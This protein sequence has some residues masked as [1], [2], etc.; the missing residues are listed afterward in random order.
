VAE[1]IKGEGFATAALGLA[2]FFR[3]PPGETAVTSLSVAFD[4]HVGGAHWFRG[5]A[6]LPPPVEPGQ[7]IIKGEAKVRCR[8]AA[9]GGLEACSVLVS[10]PAEPQLVQE[11]LKNVADLEPQLWT[12]E[13]RSTIGSTLELQVHVGRLKGVSIVR[14]ESAEPLVA[15]G[16]VAYRPQVRLSDDFDPARFYPGRAQRM[17]V[18]GQV[19]LQC[20]RLE[21]GRP[22]GCSVVS[23]SPLEYGFGAAAL[24]M[25]SYIRYSPET[26]DG[27]VVEEPIT[28]PLVFK[29][30]L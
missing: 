12:Q 19:T 9:K 25:S 16:V 3:L 21:G 29:V 28:I 10:D 23:E 14:G 5:R 7:P 8:V 15:P 27:A 13:G 22:A 2:R 11:A 17:E 1:S 4:A 24:T 18:E 26:I 6:Y 20:A 30:P